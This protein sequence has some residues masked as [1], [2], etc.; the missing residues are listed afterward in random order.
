MPEVSY[1]LG[2]TIYMYF[3]EHNPPHFHAKYNGYEG[4]FSISPLNYSNG[5]LPSRIIGLVMEWADLHLKEL[6]DNWNNLKETGKCKKI[7]PLV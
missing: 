4:T 6:L 7:K 1:F 3:K 2:I 5:N